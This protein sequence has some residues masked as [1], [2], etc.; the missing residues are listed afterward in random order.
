MYKYSQKFF[1]KPFL[2]LLLVI[3]SVFIVSPAYAGTT[4][5]IRGD[6]NRVGDII[7]LSVNI[8]GKCAVY[9]WDFPVVELGVNGRGTTPGALSVDLSAAEISATINGTALS[10]KRIYFLSDSKL[11]NSLL[12]QLDAPFTYIADKTNVVITISN[13]KRLVA[14]DYITYSPQ[15]NTDVQNGD[16]AFGGCTPPSSYESI[17]VGETARQREAQGLPVAMAPYV[18]IYNSQQNNTITPTQKIYASIPTVAPSQKVESKPN[19]TKKIPT[20]KQFNKVHP[21]NPQSLSF[22]QAFQRF[23]STLGGS[24]RNK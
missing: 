18:T 6:N 10:G 4:Y 3:F 9:N 22:F 5:T 17:A 8:S 11:N 23:L 13:I 12:I 15:L 2:S 19:P 21:K 7:S 1:L 24:L 16:N 20:P 14:N